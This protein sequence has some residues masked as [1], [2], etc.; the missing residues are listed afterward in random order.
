MKGTAGSPTT[1]VQL[2]DLVCRQ[3]LAA[4]LQHI[5]GHAVFVKVLRRLLFFCGQRE[6]V[7]NLVYPVACA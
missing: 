3:A 7:T 1:V 6:S 5:K 2:V 4:R